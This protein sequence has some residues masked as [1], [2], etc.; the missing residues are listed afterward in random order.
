MENQS[1][2]SAALVALM[3]ATWG[4]EGLTEG[5]FTGYSHNNNHLSKMYMVLHIFSKLLSFIYENNK[6]RVKKNKKKI[7]NTLKHRETV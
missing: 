2:Q 5:V 6:R 7:K 1:V 3:P 4:N